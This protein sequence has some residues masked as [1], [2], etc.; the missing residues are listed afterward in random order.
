MFRQLK[1]TVFSKTT[2]C[3]VALS[4]LA[5]GLLLSGSSQAQLHK[6]DSIYDIW[7]DIGYMKFSGDKLFVQTPNAVKEIDY[8]M[9]ES[10]KIVA[11]HRRDAYDTFFNAEN[12]ILIDKYLIKGT[13]GGNSILGY[14]GHL[15]VFDTSNLSTPVYSNQVGTGISLN[16]HLF[17][18]RYIIIKAY[19]GSFPLTSTTLYCYDVKNP[20][21]PQ[22][23][24]Q[25]DYFPSEIFLE[26]RDL[27]VGDTVYTIR[28]QELWLVNYALPTLPD[29]LSKYAIKG[30]DAKVILYKEG[31]IFWAYSGANS[32][33]VYELI[34]NN[35]IWQYDFDMPAGRKYGNSSY[36]SIK[37]KAL[38]YPTDSAEIVRIPF[39]NNGKMPVMDQVGL[40]EGEAMW[41]SSWD[42]TDYSGSDHW[43]LSDTLIRFYG[44]GIHDDWL[45]SKEISVVDSNTIFQ[46]D[47]LMHNNIQ[48]TSILI[49]ENYSG[50]AKSASWDTLD[51]KPYKSSRFEWKGIAQFD[52]RSYRGKKVHI[53]V[54][55]FSQS[56]IYTNV[57][58]SNMRIL[59]TDIHNMD[60]TDGKW[61]YRD[62]AWTVLSDDGFRPYNT[63]NEDWL[64]SDAIPVYKDSLNYLRFKSK[65]YI[66]K[67]NA[68]AGHL[69]EVLLS[70]DYNGHN[71]K[72][73]SWKKL[74]GINM[75]VLTK[76]SNDFWSFGP[77]SLDAFQ[78]DTVYIAFRY[79][80]QSPNFPEW[81][82]KDFSVYRAKG[83]IPHAPQI[84]NLNP[85]YYSLNAIK[86]LQ[87]NST[88]PNLALVAHEP[89]DLS[90][91][92][93]DFR[94]S[95]IDISK[96]DSLREAFIIHQNFESPDAFN[97]FLFKDS[98][99]VVHEDKARTIIYSLKNNHSLKKESEFTNE[100]LIPL[101]FFGDY[102][103]ASGNSLKLYDL[104]DP[105]D[106][107]Q[108]YQF[109][110]TYYQPMDV[111]K[112]DT[113]FYLLKNTGL[114]Y[115]RDIEVWSSANPSSPRKISTLRYNSSFDAFYVANNL[116]YLYD[117]R[118]VSS[119]SGGITYGE[120]TTFAYSNGQFIEK[121]SYFVKSPRDIVFNDD[122]A[123]ISIDSYK[124]DPDSVG[125]RVI[126]L[127]NPNSLEVAY[128][129]KDH[130]GC[131]QLA[132]EDDILL[133]SY[134]NT[135]VSY[136]LSDIPAPP[137]SFSLISPRGL[138]QKTDTTLLWHKSTDPNGNE[139]EYEVWMADNDQFN[140]KTIERTKDTFL[141][142]N[143]LL[144]EQTVYW[145]VWALD[146][147][148]DSVESSETFQFNLPAM[149]CLSPSG[150][151]VQG[152]TDTSLV[153]S[154]GLNDE[155][156][157]LMYKVWMADN[158][159][160]NNKTIHQT[161]DTFFNI[162]N[163][164]PGQK[165][166]WK[167]FAYNQ[168]SDSVASKNSL[169][170]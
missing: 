25:I 37:D 133:A 90:T 121:A 123:F 75:P 160:F 45:V 107:V 57:N 29:T 131:L 130:G 34:G 46:L 28:D 136:D 153:W 125:I 50:N 156:D 98:L 142:V 7:R 11:T 64:I 167:V 9:A 74:E 52:L 152:N 94:L 68:A 111:K 48:Q 15:E 95:F 110:G 70:T 132:I 102:L 58:L 2:N 36:Y 5:F 44:S 135:V 146:D 69:C 24:G 65:L 168:Q 161:S 3:F 77:V 21:Y 72:S 12:Y 151:I 60:S 140:N 76:A 116:Y 117:E 26:D 96:A 119:S 89:T 38:F 87:V 118:G 122:Y 33:D 18:G 85:D 115:S 134:E 73:A 113:L 47:Y 30:P 27:I 41:E 127:Q 67:Y 59:Q 8:S 10:P 124:N 23:K 155:K 157:Y 1:P 62:G 35:L 93:K 54:R 78:G 106:P 100:D 114:Y 86:G 53:A 139:V 128:M 145:K 88:N 144:P 92:S 13:N 126:D 51:F 79:K 129:L 150:Y 137:S 16:T 99:V 91:T 81:L 32:I 14:T 17:G 112:N 80:S 42:T 105:S 143:N 103:L 108:V 66:Y 163:L 101:H 159:Q 141:H 4:M 148:K 147:I 97:S 104:S 83:E 40:G 43:Q 55:V 164:L 162:S 71:P 154:P 149:E 31:T 22:N 165:R 170:F 63:A 61:K 19:S 138:L 49:S 120:L 39:I 109:Q 84:F 166:Y 82:I 6:S 20:A 56:T 158:E 169:K